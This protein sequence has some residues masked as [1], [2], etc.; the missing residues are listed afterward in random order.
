M[1]A[2]RWFEDMSER[3]IADTLGDATRHGEV[4]ACRARWRDCETSSPHL[5][6]AP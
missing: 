4:A 3:E 2:Y 1:I 5:E 6:V